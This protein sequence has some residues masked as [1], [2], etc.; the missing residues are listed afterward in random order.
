M[1]ARF[2][3]NHVLAN[4]LFLL[5]LVLGTLHYTLI[6]PRAKDP[7]VNFN[8][9]NIIT[10]LPGASAEDIE[11]RVTD[12]LERGIAKV[13]DIDFVSSQSRNSVSSILV[14]FEEIDERTFDRRINDLRREVRNKED[15]L[16]VAAEEPEFFE[17]TS[18]N[19]FPT[20]TLVITGLADDDNLRRQVRDIE[21]DLERLSGVDRVDPTAL[22]DPE[23][24]VLFDPQRLADLGLNPTDVADSVSSY[25]RDLSAGTLSLGDQSWNLRWLGTDPDPGYLA[26]LAILGSRGEIP[27]ADV[28]TV[29]RGRERADRFVRYLGNPAIMLA[30]FKKPRINT[31]DLL[32]RVNAY[33]DERNALSGRTGVK[34]ILADDQTDNTRHAIDVMQT[35]AL[36]GL[37]LVFLTAWLFLGSRIAA[38]TTI[39]IPFTLAG[40]FWVL[41][42][43]GETLNTQVLLGTVIALGMLVDDA[44]VVVEGIYYRIARGTDALTASMQSLREVFAPVTASVLTTMAAFLPLMLLPGILGDF[45]R[46]IPMVVTIALA[47]S[48]IEAYWMLP[49]HVMAANIDPTR[50]SR[51]HDRRERTTRWLRHSYAKVLIWVMRRPKRSLSALG[52]LMAAALAALAAGM[53]HVNF[54]ALESY[55]IFYVNVTMPAGT[56]VERTMAYTDQLEARVRSQ[57]RD[58]ELRAVV[59]YA[60]Q[61]FTQTEP[62]FGDRYG[63]IMVSLIPDNGSLRPVEQ[64]VS[65]VREVIHDL[66][67]AERVI[68]FPL[69]DGPPTTKPI[70]VKVRGDDYQELSAAADALSVLIAAIPG[71]SD[72]SDDAGAGAQELN[73]RIDS[74]AARRAGIAPGTLMRTLVLLGDG[75]VVTDFQHEGDEIDVRVR[76]RNTAIDDIERVLETPLSLPDG[77]TMPLAALIHADTRTGLSQIRHYNF[78]RAIT[79]EAELDKARIDTVTA[80][81][82]V[83]DSWATIA[84]QHPNIDLDFHGELD[85]VQESMDAIALLFA[86]GIGLIYLIL[87]TQFRSYF[88]PL[89]ILVTV[90][91]AFSGVVAGLIITGHP[92]S[93]YTL[94]GVVALAGIAVNAA[95]VLISAANQRL[96]AGMSVLHATIYAAR[97]RVVPILITTLTT[98]AGLLSLATGL[99]GQSQLWGPVA[100]AIV[101]GLGF[102]TLLTLFVIPLLYRMVM[103]WSLARKSA[104]P[105]QKR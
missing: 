38:L 22:R 49:A 73:L 54:F 27:L 47:I 41:S 31:L 62:L 26:D 3:Q 78:R 20:A 7:E 37:S 14:R 44:V 81:R 84:A 88:Q 48:L 29:Q 99:G 68:M 8:W 23:L 96:E 13:G 83:M 5:V 15:E 45:M 28:A 16:P 57:L 56:P 65:A 30:V 64:A 79:V 71:T 91:M 66:P 77:R 40:T 89:L 101:W 52:L 85:D 72:I 63:Q 6:L 58:D 104:D 43:L 92:L 9:V 80:N 55:R 59:S 39:G 17:L 86:F 36:L 21:E 18:S 97:R 93:L 11:R 1:L 69:K 82:K 19:A 46:V 35:N 50:T 67:G 95:I 98:I 103:S 24:Q 74:D 51:L 60:G 32:A 105:I 76:S 33:I 90:P 10:V 61:Q 2:L 42:H 94:Y 100:T 70:S 25:F 102:S 75:E 53:V 4:L 12:V 34:L 87:G